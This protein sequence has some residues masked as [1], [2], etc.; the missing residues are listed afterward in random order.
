MDFKTISLIILLLVAGM[1][2]YEL[3]SGTAR[4]RGG[5]LYRRGEEP[6]KYWFAVALKA[7]VALVVF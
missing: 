4:L 2:L 3:L 5:A 7:V 1:V 6:G